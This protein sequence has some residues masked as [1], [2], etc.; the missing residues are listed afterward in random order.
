MPF[1]LLFYLVFVP[2]IGVTSFKLKVDYKYDDLK[3]F[4]GLMVQIAGM[5]FT[6]MGIWI[7]FVYPNALSRLMDPGKIAIADFSESLLETRR[8]E[9]IVAAVLVSAAVAVGFT[10]VVLVKI[11]LWK[12]DFYCL[13]RDVIKAAAL[14]FVGFGTLLQFEAVASVIFANVMF[15]NDLHRKRQDR[16]AEAN[17]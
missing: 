11:A 5:V 13:H 6:I 2:L 9:R 7:A 12:T 1:R 3:D 16:K 15:I 10:L 4:I 8:L 14:S 17:I